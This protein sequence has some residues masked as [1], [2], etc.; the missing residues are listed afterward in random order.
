M[1]WPGGSSRCA[2]RTLRN[3][4]LTGQA[5]PLDQPTQR[6]RR[7]E[8]SAI[9]S[10]S[11]GAM[12]VPVGQRPIPTPRAQPLRGSARA[13][14]TRRLHPPGRGSWLRRRS[15]PG[16]CRGPSRG[17][18]GRRSGDLSHQLGRPVGANEGHAAITRPVALGSG[19]NRRRTGA[20]AGHYRQRV[21]HQREAD[22]TTRR[23]GPT[24]SGS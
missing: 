13:T 18:R 11:E 20:T 17:R 15:R 5:V 1:R 21:T 10:R 8:R 6:P 22:R 7:P 16:R 2:R 3:V 14:L 9:A 23:R 24:R 12:L 4:D 19:R